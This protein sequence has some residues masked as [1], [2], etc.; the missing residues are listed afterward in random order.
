MAY[1]AISLHEKF[2][3]F[4]DRF[5]PKVIAAMNDYQFKLVRAE[6]DFVWHSHDETDET[7]FI[8]EG[9]L[10]IEFRDGRVSLKAG[11]LFVVPKGKEHKPYAASECK[12]L[13]IEPAGIVNTGDATGSNL[14]APNEVW[15]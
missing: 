9:E 10:I 8:V 6:G 11:D 3:K 15:I 7:F 14:T 13:L 2:A 1:Q 4:S 12:V 5:Q